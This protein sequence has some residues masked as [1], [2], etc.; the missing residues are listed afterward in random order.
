MI[1]GG[2][3]DGQGSVGSDLAPHRYRLAWRSIIDRAGPILTA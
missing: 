2:D 1:T 3:R